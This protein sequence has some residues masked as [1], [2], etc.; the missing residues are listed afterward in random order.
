MGTLTASWEVPS[1]VLIDVVE[2]L[3]PLFETWLFQ[4]Y[5]LECEAFTLITDANE[6]FHREP[7]Y[8][9]L[10][11]YIDGKPISLIAHSMARASVDKQGVGQ[12]EVNY[13]LN[14]YTD[15][16]K[17][18]LSLSSVSTDTLRLAVDRSKRYLGAEI[19]KRIN[20][21]QLDVVEYRESGRVRSMN[22]FSQ[23]LFRSRDQ[24]VRTGG[25]GIQRVFVSYSHDS[26]AHKEWVRRL[27]ARLNSLGVWLI[28][29]HWD[30]ELGADIARFMESGLSEAD[31]V[32]VICTQPYIQKANRGLG[33][34]GY[35]KMIMT[36]ELV[37]D[38]RGERFIPVVREDGDGLVPTFLTSRLFIDFRNDDDFDDRVDELS[39]AI[40]GSGLK[41][42][43]LGSGS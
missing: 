41:R 24:T 4:E 33:G 18:T 12:C 34:A 21:R 19:E 13:F 23:D 42:P 16:V 20:A 43:P 40:L 30:L 22:T 32:I 1:P 27:A 15:V 35:E 28:F 2:V 17:V 25:R 14:W 38:Q 8:L 3:E 6:A 11:E 37:R 10:L 5:R 29:V 26:E 31:R 39:Q 7:N 9:S 36:G